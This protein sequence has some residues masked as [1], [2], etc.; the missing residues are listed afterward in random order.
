MLENETKQTT[1]WLYAV[2]VLTVVDI[3]AAYSFSDPIIEN[4][5]LSSFSS[6]REGIR[7]V[8]AI[9]YFGSFV[10]VARWIYLAAKVSQDAGTED[11]KYSPG[12]TVAWF[13]MPVMNLWK[14]YFAVKEHYL[15]RMQDG[16]S[17]SGDAK[18]T[19]RLWWFSFIASNV[20]AN[21][22][23]T[24]TYASG[25][26]V[27]TTA[28]FTVVSGIGLVLSCLAFIKIIRQFTAGSE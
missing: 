23:Y 20:L 12:A 2:I 10:V 27:G 4:A 15:A 6:F 1:Y 17:L 18:T 24:Q 28:I 8:S 11:L 9:F 25:E 7:V 22:S 5:D 16:R 14:P 21:T 19:F 26:V 3:L 13:L